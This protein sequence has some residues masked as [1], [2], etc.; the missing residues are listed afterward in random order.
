MPESDHKQPWSA[1]L[2]AGRRALITGA[3][4]GIGRACAL[5]LCAC[6][7]EVSAV[8]RTAEDLDSL[9]AAAG[10]RL[11]PWPADAC[12]EAFLQALERRPA[13]DILINNLGVNRPQPL[14]DI[15]RQTLDHIIDTNLRSLFSITQT[16]VRALLAAGRPGSIV[17]MGSQMGHVGSPRRTLYCATKHALEGFTKALALEL[18]EHGI[19]VNSVAPTFVDTPMT[20]PMFKDPQFADFVMQRIPMGR[21]A[22][23]TD[24]AN[25]VIYLASDLSA[26]TTGTSLRVDGGWT[27]Q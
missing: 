9:T 17:N 6:G 7:A 16:V 18:A 23:T 20:A 21:L 25:A 8:A 22:S 15:D 11:H 3:G 4:K 14:A 12:S 1:E 13:H 5:A 26:C 10:E 27:A 24:V 2:L 19:R